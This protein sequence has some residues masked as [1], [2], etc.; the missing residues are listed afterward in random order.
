M[1]GCRSE[2]EEV[3]AFDHEEGYGNRSPAGDH[4]AANEALGF[5]DEMGFLYPPINLLAIFEG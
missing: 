2:Q 4:F 1:D 5:Q 3:E